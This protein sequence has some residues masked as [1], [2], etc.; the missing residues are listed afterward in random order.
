M[1]SQSEDQATQKSFER[2]KSLFFLAAG[3][4][5]F[6]LLLGLVSGADLLSFAIAIVLGALLIFLVYE[7]YDGARILWAVL[8]M[9]TA[10]MG[11]VVLFISALRGVNSF[12]L[13]VIFLLSLPSAVISAILFFSEDARFFLANRKKQTINILDET[14]KPLQSLS[15][16][17]DLSEKIRASLPDAL[18]THEVIRVLS[19]PND[20]DKIIM[21]KFI[22]AF[23]NVFRCNRKGEIIWQAELPTNS[24]DVYTDIQWKH[25]QLVAFSRSGV[26]V[27][28][29][30]ENGKVVSPKNAT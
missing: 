2:G 13:L 29:D 16:Y 17:H 22:A 6:R 21:M 12:D 19:I 8:A 23:R 25:N 20:E 5:V 18:P 26:S 1:Q 3:L 4:F 15:E 30:V 10:A 27:I 11:V 7:G 9:M 28:L 14:R 24:N